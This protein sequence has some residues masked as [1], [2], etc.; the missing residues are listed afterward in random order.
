MGWRHRLL[1]LLARGTRTL[2]GE[3]FEPE[4]VTRL[5]DRIAKD[6]ELAARLDRL[7]RQEF[8]SEFLALYEDELERDPQEGLQ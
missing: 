1:E 8:Q 6:P 3:R 5:H 2:S 7:D 4:L